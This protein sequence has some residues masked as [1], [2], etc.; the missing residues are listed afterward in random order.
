[1][2]KED[3]PQRLL[4]CRPQSGLNDIL[5]QIEK[6]CRYG[7]ST[8]RKVIVQ[9]DYAEA[10]S[11]KDSFARYFVSRRPDLLLSAQGFASSFDRLG[12]FPR[13]L[14]GRVN[15]YEAVWDKATEHYLD[16]AT[17]EKL[18]FDFSRDYAEPLLVHHQ[19][20]GG[21]LAQ[22]VF[23]RMRVHDG[24]VDELVTRIGKIGQP[25]AGIHIRN[26]DYT[27]DYEQ[28][29]DRLSKTHRGPLFVATDNRDTLEH[30]RLVFGADRVYSFAALPDLAGE[31]LHKKTQAGAQAWE[32]NRDALLDLLM[33]A[34][35]RKLHLCPISNSPYGKY[36]GF[37]V[38]ARNLHSARPLLREALS[39]SDPLLERFP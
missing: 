30:C 36:S 32:R 7:E 10:N 14:S 39:R 29:I 6:C 16:V 37:S 13:V 26:T 9:T 15:S 24:L 5:C 27:S 3:R 2:R 31:P 19:P 12:V 11:F 22:W 1:M 35:A 25:Y 28:W 33:L 21:D 17:G 38:L 8:G 34:L 18:T 23:L 4:L 20:R